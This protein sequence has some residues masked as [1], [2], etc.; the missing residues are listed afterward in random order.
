M[1]HRL[2]NYAGTRSTTYLWTFSSALLLG[3]AMLSASFIIGTRSA[4]TGTDTRNYAQFFLSL[5]Y[6]SVSTRLE[7]GFVLIAQ[8]LRTLGLGVVGYQTALFGLLLGTVGLATRTYFRELPYRRSYLTFLTST[9]A[10]L[11]VSPVF[12]NASI[13]AIRQGLASLVVFSAL[14]CFHQRR[15]AWFVGL[16]A[17]AVS[18]HYS[19]ILYVACAPVLLLKQR[20]RLAISIIAFFLYCSGVSMALVASFAPAVYATVMDYHAQTDY[21]AGVRIDFAIFSIFWFTL[22]YALS[23]FM[24]PRARERIRDAAA[25]YLVLM[26]PFFALGW[27]NFSNRLLLPAWLSVSL[28]LAALLQ[29]SPAPFLRHPLLLRLC[30]AAATCIFYFLVTNSI[31][32]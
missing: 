10:F 16:G 21:R 15:W 30:L 6:G 31:I 27:G 24:Q 3:A 4:D 25:V 11:F 7:P 22:P 5:G 26:L 19:A 29:D 13:N 8:A 12:V 17:M 20:T 14:L 32:I 18:V 23:T 1:K 28:L 9:L 2:Q